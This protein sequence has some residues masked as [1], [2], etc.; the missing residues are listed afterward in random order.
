MTRRRPR[1]RSASASSGVSRQEGARLDLSL[2][3]PQRTAET[4]TVGKIGKRFGQNLA[5]GNHEFQVITS[6]RRADV[7]ETTGWLD[8]EFTGDVEEIERAINRIREKGCS[9]DPIELNIV[10]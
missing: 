4:V 1:P 9:V 6:I 8:V 5:G 3:L 2:A 10:E 7:R